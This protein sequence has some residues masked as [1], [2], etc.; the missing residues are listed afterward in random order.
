MRQ[1][2]LLML[3]SLVHESANYRLEVGLVGAVIGCINVRDLPAVKE[4]FENCGTH[5]AGHAGEGKYV[6]DPIKAMEA[7]LQSAADT[8]ACLGA[9][10]KGKETTVIKLLFKLVDLM[11][12][13]NVEMFFHPTINLIHTEILVG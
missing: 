9:H 4:R 5:G 12:F 11:I 3:R 13:V 2:L 8:Q 10:V 6:D 7:V 1:P